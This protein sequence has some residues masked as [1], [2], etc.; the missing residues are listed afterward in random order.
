[1]A[2]SPD[3]DTDDAGVQRMVVNINGFEELTAIR[4]ALD[5]IRQDIDWWINNHPR[6][7]WLPV[8]PVTS[9]PA[10]LFAPANDSRSSNLPATHEAARA[11]PTPKPRSQT[12]TAPNDSPNAE[13]QFCC[14]APDLQWTGDPH[15][16]G[17]ACMNCGYIVADCGSVVMQA[18]PEADPEPKD[19]QRDLFLGE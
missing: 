15:F 11:T 17:V 14:D 16:P 5:G 6:D 19:Q 13:A 7:Q 10:H 12:S 4:E 1:M 2:P 18:S 9:V 8:Q 3:I